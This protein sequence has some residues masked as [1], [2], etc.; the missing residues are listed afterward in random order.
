MKKLTFILVAFISF[1]V[2]AQKKKNGTA[3]DKHPGITL[4]EA[5]NKAFVEADVEKLSS[6]LADDFKAYNALSSNKDQEGT[7]KKNF[8]GQSQWWNANIDYL[9]ITQAKPAYPDAIEYKGGQI[10]VQTWERIYG[11]NKQT[12]VELEMP[13]H[14]LYQLNKDATKILLLMDY[15]DRRNYM[16]MWDAWPGND[17]KNGDIY[18]NHENINSVRK[19]MYSFLNGDA[20]KAYSFFDENAVIDDINEPEVLT[21]EQGKERDKVMFAEWSLDAIDESGYPD[22]LEYDWRQSKVVQ[23]WWNFRMTNNKTGKKIVLKV[24]ILDDFNDGGKI[25]KRN[26][27]YNGA[28]LK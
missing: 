23:S 20:E 27:Y 15:T 7:P 24:F 1:S 26:L 8:I 2:S 13:I 19:V 14:R 9:K 10:W 16:R 3:Y 18:I 25:I 11:V 21:F 28:L 17:R 6:I 4:I 12:G 5:F 22:Y